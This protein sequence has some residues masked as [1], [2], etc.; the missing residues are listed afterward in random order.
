MSEAFMSELEQTLDS[1]EVAEMIEK[2]HSK[3][4]RDLRRYEEQ[5]TEAKIGFSD[6]FR[7]SEYKDSTGRTLPCYRITKKGCEFIAHKLT[8]TKG[9]LFTARYINRFHEME[10]IIKGQQEK[11]LP[12]FIKRF[13]GK[14]IVLWRDFESVT[15]VNIEKWKPHGWYE[16]MKAEQDYNAW[17]TKDNIIKEQ[18]EQEYGFDYGEDDC[19]AY[20]SLSGAKK[21]LGLLDRDGE[22]EIER[23]SK[24]LLLNEIDRI[25]TQNRRRL[26]GNSNTEKRFFRGAEYFQRQI[27]I[28]LYGNEIEV[29]C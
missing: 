12:W 8:G 26:E 20:F 13:R 14:Y 4:L 11:P 16:T 25:K 19:M 28:T 2:E 22:T 7:E 9:T 6:F 18:F 5:F 24:K 15:G 29:K 10:N 17:A 1:R 23:N 3:L 27:C 21:T